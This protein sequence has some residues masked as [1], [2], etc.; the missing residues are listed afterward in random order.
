MKTCKCYCRQ[1]DS[2]ENYSEKNGLSSYLILTTCSKEPLL[3][4]VL[5]VFIIHPVSSQKSESRTWIY[6]R[7]YDQTRPIQKTAPPGLKKLLEHG[8]TLPVPRCC[9]NQIVNKI[10]H[11]GVLNIRNCFIHSVE[12]HTS[13]VRVSLDHLPSV[14]S[15]PEPVD[16]GLLVPA[17]GHTVCASVVISSVFPFRSCVNRVRS[18]IIQCICHNS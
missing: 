5:T 7:S 17:H 3:I 13:K 6:D 10:P 4:I 11:Q 15:F 2:Y 1:R 16:D 9:P 8:F 12:G 14:S 18:V